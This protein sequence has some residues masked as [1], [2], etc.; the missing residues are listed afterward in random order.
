MR[1]LLISVAVASLAACGGGGGDS[2]A[3]PAASTASFALAAGYKSL[4][5]AG[6][7]YNFTISGTCGGTATES[8]AG[9][10]ASSTFEGSAALQSSVTQ[11]LN[12]TGCTPPTVA[13]T[14]TTYQD[15]ATYLPIGS[16]TVGTEY[17][18]AQVKA[19]ALPTTVKVGDNAAV[20]TLNVYSDSTK[21][22]LTGTRTASYAVTA[23]TSATAIVTIIQK[24]F[25]GTTVQ[26]TQQ[27]SYRMATDGTLSLIGIDVVNSLGTHLVLTRV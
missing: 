14:S 23:D 4:V 27:T 6:G 8:V 18:V 20:V 1:K 10:T 21:T 2:S 9:A 16:V 25:V 24:D 26:S 11:Q 15:P 19:A 5:L 22:T 12:L 13:I 17:V 3:A 7:G